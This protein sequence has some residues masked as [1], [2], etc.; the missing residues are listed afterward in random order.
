MPGT[1]MLMPSSQPP[2]AGP[3]PRARMLGLNRQYLGHDEDTDVIAFAH[4]APPR[5]TPDAPI[6]DIFISGWMDAR[7]AAELGHPVLREALT[8]VAHGALHLLGHDDHAPRRRAAMFRRQD[9]VLADL[10]L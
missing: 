4:D 3:V 7:Q 2:A 10:G 1:L 5:P 9:E 6:G 8:L